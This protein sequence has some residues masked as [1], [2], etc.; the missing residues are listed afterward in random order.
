M[1]WIRGRPRAGLSGAMETTLTPAYMLPLAGISS[2]SP[3]G[4]STDTRGGPAS[5][6]R[7]ARNA[8][9]IV[10]AAVAMDSRD[11]SSQGIIGD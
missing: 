10:P 9:S 6:S 8:A 7:P 11:T 1:P 3:P 2:S 4:T 5:G